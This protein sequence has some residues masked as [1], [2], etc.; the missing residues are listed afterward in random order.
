MESLLL[1]KTIIDQRLPN[2][3]AA[4]SK[5]NNPPKMRVILVGKNQ[6]SIAYVKHKE[7]MCS[8]IGAQFDLVRLPE[9]INKSD[10]LKEIEKLNTDKSINGGFVQL[11]LPTHLRD[12]DTTEL[13][14]KEKDVDGFG[15]E[16]FIGL[17]KNNYERGFIPCTPKG[18][19]SLLKENNITVFFA[20]TGRIRMDSKK[21]Q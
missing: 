10:F 17:I 4:C 16:S 9:D 5:M 2:L 12:I 6:A 19:M 3:K 11:P 13:I 8:K 14:A 15:I 18:I 21:E 20:D 7:K 1:A